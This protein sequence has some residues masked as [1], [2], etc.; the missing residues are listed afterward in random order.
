MNLIK[1]LKIESANG[2]AEPRL[3]KLIYSMFTN[4]LEILCNDVLTSVIQF[5]SLFQEQHQ[6]R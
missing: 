3:N 6:Q 1:H 4:R 2:G 5:V